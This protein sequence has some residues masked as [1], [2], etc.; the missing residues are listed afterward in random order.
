MAIGYLVKE[1]ETWML[2][3]SRNYMVVLQRRK[4]LKFYSSKKN[5]LFIYFPLMFRIKLMLEKN[6]TVPQ[7]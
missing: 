5:Y 4:T 2:W 6:R 7:G 1:K 3:S